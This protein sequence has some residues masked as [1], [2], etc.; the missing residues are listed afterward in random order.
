VNAL[1]NTTLWSGRS[2][3]PVRV[4]TRTGDALLVSA[5][6]PRRAANEDAALVVERDDATLVAVADGMGGLENGAEASRLTLERVAA[7]FAAAGASGRALVDAVVAGLEEANARILDARLGGGT[8][9]AGVIVE[10]DRA[11]MLH[12]GDSE[13]F[14]L[15]SDGEV[16]GHTI[17]HSPVGRELAAGRIAEEAA[18]VHAERHLLSQHVGM[19]RICI[20]EGPSRPLDAGDRLLVAT[21]GLL[22]NLLREEI[23]ARACRLDADDAAR[24]LFDGARERMGSSRGQLGKPD[25]LTFVLH[26]PRGE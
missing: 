6:S 12:V 24:L 9:F 22:D 16:R 10:R 4:A 17:P 14:H 20:E 15:S 25:D 5:A 7:Q 21:D 23:V 2:A 8:T 3:G 13:A 1:P 18:L 19:E 11:T 26:V